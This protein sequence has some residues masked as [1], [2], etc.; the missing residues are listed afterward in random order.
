MQKSAATSILPS[1]REPLA[2]LGLSV[3]RARQARRWTIEETATRVMAS[4]ATIKRLE[5]GD[6]SV[7]V[8][9]WANV[10]SQLALLDRVVA[11]AS[12]SND[13]LGEA[14][15][16]RETPKRVRK[17]KSEEDRFDF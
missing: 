1:A 12:P 2:Q 6:P 8:G 4:P 17:R 16:A 15:R 11:A 14:L 7:A 13:Q 10:L 5:A 9:T 3:R